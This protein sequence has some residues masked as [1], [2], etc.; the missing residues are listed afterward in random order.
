MNLNIIKSI[1]SDSNEDSSELDILLSVDHLLSKCRSLFLDQKFYDMSSYHYDL[2]K[3]YMVKAIDVSESKSGNLLNYSLIPITVHC[4]QTEDYAP[5]VVNIDPTAIKNTLVKAG[6]YNDDVVFSDIVIPMRTLFGGNIYNTFDTVRESLK[7]NNESYIDKSILISESS[8]QFVFYIVISEE[9]SLTEIDDDKWYEK[10]RFIQSR[11]SKCCGTEI[12]ILPPVMPSVEI[13]TSILR[14]SWPRLCSE[15][16]FN[17][18]S[19]IDAVSISIDSGD[20]SF[21]LN[22]SSDGEK[23]ATLELGGL[24]NLNIDI[25]KSHLDIFAKEHSFHNDGIDVVKNHLPSSK[26]LK[27][28]KKFSLK[29]I[30]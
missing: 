22:V 17:T 26:P 28:K 27:R 19:C 8:F 13:Y 4:L 14:D 16:N 10:L 1:L 7:I 25:L 3:S 21:L 2:L 12:S 18:V 6:V 30:K 15:L 11:I 23:V 20:K 24:D 29:I 9:N 5:I